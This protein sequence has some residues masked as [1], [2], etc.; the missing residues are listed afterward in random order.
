MKV[1]AAM[2]AAA[3]C[4]AALYAIACG[5]GDADGPLRASGYVEATEV[6]VSPEVGGRVQDGGGKP[7]QGVSVKLQRA[8]KEADQQQTSDTEG[9]FR[10]ASLASGVYIATASLE[11]YGSVTCPGV[12]IVASLTRRLDIKM[13]PAEGEQSA[14]SCQIAAGE[15]R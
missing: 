14:S 2:I 1:R 7:L 13:M 8:G 5:S 10:F 15:G 9:N 3:V 11:G 6:R 12:R 4:G